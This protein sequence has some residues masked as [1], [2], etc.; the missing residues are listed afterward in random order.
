[1]FNVKVYVLCFI[2]LE[3]LVV[4]MT[5]DRVCFMFFTSTEGPRD[6]VIIAK[7]Y[8]LYFIILKKLVVCLPIDRVKVLCFTFLYHTRF[9]EE[10]VMFIQ[11]RLIVDTTI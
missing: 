7:V 4:D 3:G 9:L 10:G 1:M 8:V 11:Q 5:I 2:I 6:G